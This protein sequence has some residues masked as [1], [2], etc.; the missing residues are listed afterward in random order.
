MSKLYN[1]I[2]ET[3][4]EMSNFFKDCVPNISNVKHNK[5]VV[6]LDHMFTKNNCHQEIQKH[7]RKC[8]FSEDFIFKAVNEVID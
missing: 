3:A 6:T 7:S 1:S 4:S 5:L 2:D 8:V